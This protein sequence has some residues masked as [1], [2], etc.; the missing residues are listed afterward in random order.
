MP[1]A[2]SH[3]AA[4]L[5]NRTL[6]SDALCLTAV[7]GL[8]VDEALARFDAAPRTRATTF[9]E[10]GQAS[11][12]AYPDELPLVVADE[13][14]GWV[15]LAE[16][17]GF[18]GSLPE[19]LAAL[20]A[21][22]TAVTA[23]WNVD[24]DNTITLA[25]DGRIL[26][27]MDFVLD[28]EPT[29]EL[30]VHLDGLDFEDPELMCASA[31]AFVERVTGVRLGADWFAEPH[32]T[33]TITPSWRFESFDP[34]SWLAVNAPEIFDL[35]PEAGTPVLREIA[36]TAARRACAA[37]GVEDGLSQSR[38]QLTARLRETHFEALDLRWDRCTPTDPCADPVT[39]LQADHARRYA[40]TTAERVL[41]ARAHA[42]AAVRAC[43]AED[44]ITAA[45]QALINACQ[46]DR[47]HWADL[48]RQ[49]ATRLAGAR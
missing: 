23:F 37:N 11:I 1:D 30:T 38:D 9:T 29:A 45:A 43:L 34:A 48:R 8:S 19:V 41:V 7:R 46:A 49:A 12:S 31:L 4:M 26:D 22:T 47:A 40:D 28:H 35:L 42:L 13:L 24:V 18:H 21:G 2:V 6:P 33:A 16:H 25:R 14:D 5:A 44:A 32:R 10:A 3:Y 36:T 15:F 27:A 17:G 39:R 20:S